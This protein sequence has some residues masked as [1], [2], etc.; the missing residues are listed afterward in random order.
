[1]LDEHGPSATKVWTAILRL[2]L[3]T[4]LDT[5]ARAVEIALARGTLDPQAVA[6][7]M[8]QRAEASMRLAIREESP[9]RMAQVVDLAV[10]RTAMLVE[11]AS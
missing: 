8:R 10:Y 9:A 1:L 3:E 5:L 2:A 6:L 11:H 4:S 7:L